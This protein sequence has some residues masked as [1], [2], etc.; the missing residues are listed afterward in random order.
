M[1]LCV[2]SGFCLPVTTNRKLVMRN[3]AMDFD[4][5]PFLRLRVLARVIRE[6]VLNSFMLEKMLLTCLLVTKLM[7]TSAYPSASNDF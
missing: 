1:M 7:Y 2:N 4:N 5:R 3:A 6:F